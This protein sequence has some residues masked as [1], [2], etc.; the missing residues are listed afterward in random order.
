MDFPGV[1]ML[2]IVIKGDVTDI[3]AK[4]RLLCWYI[5]IPLQHNINRISMEY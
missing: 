4:N 1:L 3:R 2:K 5:D